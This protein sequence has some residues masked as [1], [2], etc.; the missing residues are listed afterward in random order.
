MLKNI[1]PTPFSAPLY[2]LI[3][4]GKWASLTFHPGCTRIVHEW[5]LWL[6]L[7]DTEMCINEA[8]IW[9]QQKFHCRQRVVPYAGHSSCSKSR[10]W[11]GLPCIIVRTSGIAS[12]RNHKSTR[13]SPLRMGDVSSQPFHRLFHKIL[14]SLSIFWVSLSCG[15]FNFRI[16]ILWFAKP[17]KYSKSFGSTFPWF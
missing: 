6:Q 3:L 14:L 11:N 16:T 5:F 15:Y 4:P 13:D 12:K 8:V 10:W 17:L 2:F 9:F 1:E 7:G